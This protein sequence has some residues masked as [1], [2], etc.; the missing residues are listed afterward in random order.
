MGH[1]NDQGY[2]FTAPVAFTIT[3]LRVPTDVGTGVQNIE[4]LKFT[5]APPAY[6]ST[7]TSFTS[8]AYFKNVA[9]TGYISV[10]IS[11][12][13]G[14]I[15]GILGARGTTSLKNSYGQKGPYATKISNLP[16]SLERLIFQKNLNSQKADA[17]SGAPT[18]TL[19]RIEMQ[20]KP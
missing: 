2:W 10:N 3:G 19:G 16:A 4:V 9:G 20:Y 17:L 8:L 7:T 1:E 18:G 14:D 6:S 11:V 5:A 12:A 13:K 15:I